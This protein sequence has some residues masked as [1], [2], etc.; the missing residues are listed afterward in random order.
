MRALYRMS[1][2]R[3]NLR[4]EG[5]FIEHEVNEMV[6]VALDMAIKFQI[7][8]SVLRMKGDHGHTKE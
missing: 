2:R 5:K 6:L 4:K 7:L 3:I 1:L 8:L